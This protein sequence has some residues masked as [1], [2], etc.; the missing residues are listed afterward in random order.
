MQEGVRGGGHGAPV[1]KRGA[2]GAC[3]IVAGQKVSEMLQL[4]FSAHKA[5]M[6]PSKAV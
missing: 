1:R 4:F 6:M 5:T 3:W 2:V